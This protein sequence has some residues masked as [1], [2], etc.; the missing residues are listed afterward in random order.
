MALIF[1]G[2]AW[3]WLHVIEEFLEETELEKQTKPLQVNTKGKKIV[4]IRLPK[5]NNE[6][7]GML[8]LLGVVVYSQGLWK[9]QIPLLILYMTGI[10]DF[11]S[12]IYSFIVQNHSFSHIISTILFLIILSISNIG[13]VYFHQPNSNQIPEILFHG[14]ISLFNALRL[15]HLLCSKKKASQ[16]FNIYQVIT[17][18]IQ[19]E[20]SP[21]YLLTAQ[22]H[23]FSEI[24][25]LCILFISMIIRFQSNKTAIE[26]FYAIHQLINYENENIELTNEFEYEYT[27][28]MLAALQILI[29][30][31][32]LRFYR[33]HVSLFYFEVVFLIYQQIR[34][35][36]FG[37]LL[38][39]K[40]ILESQLICVILL[41]PIMIMKLAKYFS[42]RAY[43]SN[44]FTNLLSV[45]Y[46]IYGSYF[47]L[48]ILE[49]IQ[50]S[51]IVLLSLDAFIDDYFHFDMITILLLLMRTFIL[52]SLNSFP[53]GL[54]IMSFVFGWGKGWSSFIGPVVFLLCSLF[55]IDV[56]F[57]FLF[58][59]FIG[60]VSKFVYVLPA[61]LVDNLSLIYYVII[62]PLMYLSMSGEWFIE[63]PHFKIK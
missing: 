61:Y 55:I 43:K 4:K 17:E 44:F 9:W 8:I 2:H 32:K 3:K 62:S 33:V 7:F 48:G 29:H 28:S 34:L 60:M 18:T 14:I 10:F 25:L 35:Y 20:I 51:S 23:V 6:F 47:T 22:N 12:P 63:F 41:I 49:S 13:Y 36:P 59:V 39:L 31:P 16:N 58:F 26:A 19:I 1:F 24:I 53:I 30:I 5:V 21:I 54:C 50:E 37:N 27:N 52:I 57:A 56:V 15:K 40:Y 45:I 46:G 38:V 11:L 42:S